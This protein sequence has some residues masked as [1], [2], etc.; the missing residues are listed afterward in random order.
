MS[1]PRTGLGRPVAN[2]MPRPTPL[3][4]PDERRG[5]WVPLLFLLAPLVCCVGPFLFAAL[6]TAGAAT[7]GTVGGVIGGLVIAAAA[8]VWIRHR[9]RAGATC[10]PPVDGAW[11]R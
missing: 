6:A 1:L 11:R 9:R 3:R 8:V 2:A 10:C 5:R 4:P 7:L